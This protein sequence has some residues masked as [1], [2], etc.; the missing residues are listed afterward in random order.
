M[1]HASRWMVGIVVGLLLVA[2]FALGQAPQPAK[3]PKTL[4]KKA[5]HHKARHKPAPL[6][7]MVL[8]PMP[9]GPLPQVPMDQLPSA[10]P[11]VSYKDGMLT[12][13]A[14]NSTLN[15]ILREVHNRTGAS[16]DVP[17]N[18]GERVVTRLGPGPA[19]DILANLL[20]GSTFNYVMLGSASDPGALTTVILTVKTAGVPGAAVASAPQPTPGMPPARVGPIQ[21]APAVPAMSLQASSAEEDKSEDNSDEQDAEDNADQ[22]QTPG[23]PVQPN[24]N[25]NTPPGA[26][27][28]NTGPKTPE[29]ILEMM[30]KLPQPN[31]PPPQ[32]PPSENDQPPE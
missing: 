19:R 1:P 10:P 25:T 20:N 11:R 6:P 8:P 7:P 15:D 28:P 9:S 3:A 22:E 18:P 14:Q 12:I 26:P 2:P 30:R 32:P 24:V 21:P 4:P 16:I 5:L 31:Q 27:E 29:Q 13:V 17:S 23:V